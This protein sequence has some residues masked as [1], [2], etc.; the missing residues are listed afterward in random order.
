MAKKQTK[1]FIQ[2]N[3]WDYT[4]LPEQLLYEQSKKDG[5]DFVKGAVVLETAEFEIAW[6]YE[7]MRDNKI[8]SLSPHLQ[9]IL[10]ERVWKAGDWNKSKSYIRDFWKGLSKSTPFLF[11][12]LDLILNN[13]T[14]AKERDKNIPE[15]IEQYNEI[16]K[17]LVI[18]N[19][20]GFQLVNLDG[21]TRTNVSIV[22]YINGDFPLVSTDVNVV[23]S[24]SVLNQNGEYEDISNKLFTDLDSF[25]QGGF[26]STKIICNFLL[27]GTLDDISNVLISINSNEKWKEWQELYNGRFCKV[28]TNRIHSVIDL[29]D[30]GPVK[31]W[32]IKYLRQQ[33]YKQDYSEFE[34]FIAEILYWVH[35]HQV[36]TIND[37]RKAF[38]Q[39]GETVPSKNICK[40]VKQYILEIMD[41]YT[42]DKSK[43]DPIFI[44]GYIQFRDILDNAPKSKNNFWYSHFEN[45]PVHSILS[46]S[47]MFV[48]YAKTDA[49]LR[50]QWLVD[51]DGNETLNSLSWFLPTPDSEPEHL[52]HGYYGHCSGGFNFTSIKGRMKMLINEFVK[53][54]KYLKQNHIVSSIT[55]MPKKIDVYVASNFKTLAGKTIDPTK[56]NNLVRGHDTSRANG[57]SDDV[58]NIK[59]QTS[60]GNASYS[61]RNLIKTAP[62][63]AAS[64]QKK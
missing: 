59:A 41:N 10:L 15:V 48:W 22:P 35:N 24:V 1:E 31:A 50:A 63:K 32:F 39:Q 62:K 12:P 9:R 3:W 40:F 26:F 23:S 36:P 34:L 7:K 53:D 14:E 33:K 60:K 18:L 8:T 17:E 21:Q 30:D 52:D 64:K 57:G 16:E 37:L 27:Q 2:T 19:E 49:K 20:N 38:I 54:F 58:R 11:V 4:K 47:Q 42:D 45:T 28:Y 51:D 46:T 43:I 56:K 61:K 13:L 29:E 5:T 55:T 44:Q 25:Q 6:L